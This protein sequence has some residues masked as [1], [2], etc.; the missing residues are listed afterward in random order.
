MK[1]SDA[2]LFFGMSEGNATPA[3]III[4]SYESIFIFQDVPISLMDRVLVTEVAEK[5][6]GM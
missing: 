2:Y 5:L 4:T 1:G 3:P 6:G